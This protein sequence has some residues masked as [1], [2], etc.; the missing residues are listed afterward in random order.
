MKRKSLLFVMML[1]ALSVT[2]MVACSK[3]KYDSGNNNNPNTIYMKGMVFSNTSL[4]IKTG[5][6]VTW[7]NDDNT[8]HTVTAD[9]G[10]F[11]SGNLAAGSSFTHTFTSTGTFAYHCKIHSNMTGV[12]V[13]TAP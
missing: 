8:T 1:M 2:L 5:T 10:S 7:M 4:S 13:V 11:D 3:S 12:I 6:T 9:D